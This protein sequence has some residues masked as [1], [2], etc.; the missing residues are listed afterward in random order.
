MEKPQAHEIAAGDHPHIESE[1]SQSETLFCLVNGGECAV[2]VDISANPEEQATLQAALIPAIE[3]LDEF[4]GGSFAERFKGLETEIGDGLTDG[5]AEAFGDQNRIVM[6]RQKMLMTVREE[7]AHLAELGLAQAGDRLRAV[8]PEL[9]D[10]PA[11]FYEFIHEIGHVIEE[12]ADIDKP[13]EQRLQRAAGLADESPTQLYG[14]DPSRPQEAFAEAFAHMVLGQP[15]EPEMAA[16][17]NQAIIDQQAQPIV[18][19]PDLK[20]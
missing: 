3:K 17:V 13:K 8:P 2:T 6:D 11:A 20:P 18:S 7:D 19:G 10:K 1:H 5:G 14:Q 15:V 4:F 9:H 12:Q 16:I